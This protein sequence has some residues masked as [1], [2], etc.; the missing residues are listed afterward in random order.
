MEAT[1]TTALPDAEQALLSIYRLAH[2]DLRA[3]C[4]VY[5]A[6]HFKIPDKERLEAEKFGWTLKAGWGQPQIRTADTLTKFID[7]EAALQAYKSL[8]LEIFRGAGK[9]TLGALGA[10]LWMACTGRRKNIVLISDTKTQAVDHLASIIDELEHNA[11]LQERY[12]ELYVDERETKTDRKR[13]DD[14]TLKNG[15]RIFARGAGQRM[16]GS[17]WKALRPD[18]VVLDDPQGEGHAESVAQMQKLTRWFDRV[19]I[20]MGAS[21][22]LFIV[23][24]TPLR[25]D[26]IIAHVAKKPATYHLRFPA[27]ENG[28]PADPFRFP[29]ERLQ[30]LEQEMGPTAYAQEMKLQPAG[31]NQKPFERAWFRQW[32]EIPPPE[33]GPGFIGW[34]PAAKTKEQNDYTGIVCGR[35]V[36]GKLVIF[37]AV[38]ARLR[39]EVQ[40]ETVVMLAMKYGIRRVAVETIAAQEW[41][42]AFLQQQLE[43]HKYSLT[44]I[45]QEHHTDKRIFLETT[46]QAPAFRG[47]IRVVPNAETEVLLTQVSNFP[48]DA[49]DDLADALADCWLAY[50]SSARRTGQVRGMDKV[51]KFIAAT[52]QMGYADVAGVRR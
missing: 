28:I 27:E 22:C 45:Q 19:V 40:A 25:H 31:D 10:I 41:A 21:N 34:D 5:L 3:F 24:A 52:R 51:A 18:C 12:G 2:N 43:K 47:D 30:H 16:R 39:I 4:A 35:A 1:A 17:K 29:I 44:V 46:L 48:L 36:E 6:H 15:V 7:R 26:D 38:N 13:Q 49:H 33:V 50:V 23:I 9:S 8:V 32:P 20:G 11:L 14:I 42:L 37:R